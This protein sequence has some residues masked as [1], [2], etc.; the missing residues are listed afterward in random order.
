VIHFFEQIPGYFT[1]QGFYA[2]AAKDIASPGPVRPSR[3]VEVG[4]YAGRSAAFLGVELMNN[5]VAAKID[6]VDLFHGGVEGVRATLAPIKPVLGAILAE[7]SVRAA[8]M[9]HDAS[10][11]MVFLDADHEYES[12]ARD[13]DTWL[14][15]VKRGGIL[16]GHDY[17]EP[18]GVVK[19]VN[20]RFTRFEV[21][22]GERYAGELF[23]V[24]CVRV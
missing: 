17:C 4:V 21:W 14:P 7:D 18:F 16:A 15:K 6:L 5:R 9:Y 3:L 13:I 19:A 22:P 20:E 12:I 11:D 8:A 1:F 2:W 10:V 23:P 24:W